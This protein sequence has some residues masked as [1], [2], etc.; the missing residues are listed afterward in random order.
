MTELPTRI[1]TDGGVA[2]ITLAQPD[3]KNALA[4][5]LVESL[6]GH[7]S[8]A[9]LDPDVRALVVT[10]EGSTFCAGADLKA[11]AAGRH[12]V[13]ATALVTL[14]ETILDSPKPT[15]ARV[16]GH[17][18]GGGVGLA[19]AFDISVARADVMFGFTEARV[20]VAPAVISVV[21]LPKLRAA[22][23]R[24]LFLRSSRFSA[25]RAAEVGLINH[26]VAADLFEVTMAEVI[27]DVLAGGPMALVACKELMAQVPLLGRFEAFEWTAELSTELFGSAEATEGI[28]AFLQRRHAPWIPGAQRTM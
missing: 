9:I 3:N 23:A 10:N 1:T 25:V 15:I 14:L 20:G 19:A 21:C 8:D 16:D 12:G 11:A 28:N 26:A 2:T 6:L 24:E 4:V 22:D 5:D 27:A 18:M 17:C 7:L 13:S